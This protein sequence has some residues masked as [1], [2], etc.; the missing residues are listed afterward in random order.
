MNNPTAGNYG[1]LSFKLPVPSKLDD[2]A[3]ARQPLYKRRACDKC[4]SRKT[5]CDGK[6]PCTKCRNLGLSSCHYSAIRRQPPKRRIHSNPRHFSPQKEI[7]LAPTHL[8]TKTFGSNCLTEAAVTPPQTPQEA[9]LPTPLATVP[10]QPNIMLAQP[11]MPGALTATVP[12]PSALEAMS[13]LPPAPLAFPTLPH[14]PAETEPSPLAI[15]ATTA[16]ST[17]QRPIPVNVVTTGPDAAADFRPID[18]SRSATEN[19]RKLL[20]ISEQLRCLTNSLE[21]EATRETTRALVPQSRFD[22]RYSSTSLVPDLDTCSS[23]SS[24]RLT[25]TEKPVF[26]ILSHGGSWHRRIEDRNSAC[27]EQSQDQSRRSGQ[28]SNNRYHHSNSQARSQGSS[29]P[30]LNN[31]YSEQFTL[32]FT[33]I[34]NSTITLKSEEE[35]LYSP[36]LVYSLITIFVNQQVRLYQKIYLERFYRKLH[37]REISPLAL[38]F[39]LAYGSSIT[40]KDQLFHAYMR[41]NVAQIYFNRFCQLVMKEIECPSLES[42]YIIFQIGSIYTTFKDNSGYAFYLDLGK[43]L[44]H[45]MKFHLVDHGDARTNPMRLP[46]DYRESGKTNVRDELLREYKRRAYWEITAF[47]NLI[48]SMLGNPGTVGQ[49]NVMVNAIDDR[50][51]FKIL[52]LPPEE[53]VYPPI[54][55]GMRQTLCGYPGLT[56]FAYLSG[57]VANLRSRVRCEDPEAALQYY[58]TLNEKLQSNHDELVHLYPLPL[59]V[60]NETDIAQRPIHYTS[61]YLVHTNYHATVI[62][63][64][65]HNWSIVGPGASA[66]SAGQMFL[67]EQ[68]P[69]LHQRGLDAADFITRHCFLFFKVLSPKY[70]TPVVSGSCFVALYKYV[71]T[72][73]HLIHRV[74]TEFKTP[75]DGSHPGAPM[76]RDQ[77]DQEIRRLLTIIRDY[78]LFLDDM[79]D[80][81]SYVKVYT[82]MMRSNLSKIMSDYPETTH[83]YF[84][85][86]F[87]KDIVV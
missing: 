31:P 54:I 79:R 75:V 65:I 32:Y 13:S 60:P 50:L 14:L 8:S 49:N 74:D 84:T 27:Q 87:G 38:N 28:A 43:S 57:E 3:R 53:D 70:Y 26:R 76:Q 33:R 30:Y 83:K 15:A 17:E 42:A 52:H 20:S 44:M 45:Q 39:I 69:V 80:Y 37:R 18:M 36:I 82:A 11:T 12:S 61:I 25:P 35:I 2:G 16:G 68:H 72:L 81:V 5:G 86:E 34:S 19:H 62:M 23:L 40:I 77:I 66:A 4:V 6:Q 48:N 41:K 73:R 71:D 64:N 22:A 78:Y 56:R 51:L 55:P 10:P 1:V 21:T 67:P 46:Q 47:Y 9:K 63:L 85:A 7:A 24:H 29:P 58:F 59:V